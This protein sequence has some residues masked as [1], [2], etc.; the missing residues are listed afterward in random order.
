MEYKMQLTK[1]TIRERI[2]SVFVILG[3]SILLYQPAVDF[4]LVFFIAVCFM[5]LLDQKTKSR[6]QF[7]QLQAE[8]AAL[9][10]D[11]K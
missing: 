5:Y 3:M 2:E 10:A 11:I 9:K 7:E 6:K 1:L 8:L 4:K